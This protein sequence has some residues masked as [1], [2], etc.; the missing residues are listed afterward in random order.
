MPSWPGM[1]GPPW[2]ILNEK[3]L[4]A[5]AGYFIL[6]GEGGFLVG[7]PSKQSP[8]ISGSLML[9]GRMTVLLK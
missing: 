1:N 7:F 2:G 6:D 4:A 3:K 8:G 5:A 9:P